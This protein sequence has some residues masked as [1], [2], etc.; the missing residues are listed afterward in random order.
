[1]KKL[2]LFLLAFTM[3]GAT[4]NAATT[5]TTGV[6]VGIDGGSLSITSPIVTTNFGNIVMDA[7]TKVVTANLGNLSVSDLTATGQGWRVLVQSSQF[8]EVG[9]AGFVLPQNSLTL[10]KPSSVVA[11]GGT[12]SPNPTIVPA[13]N[14]VIDDGNQHTVLSAALNN[15]MGSYDMSFANPSL[16]LLLDA[17]TAKVDSVNYAGVPTPYS[18]TITWNVVTGP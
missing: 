17:A 12:T 13:G 7:Q 5:G 9:G 14:T 1:M 11:T 16:S 8:S 15:G 3:F 18:A 6:N 2:G 10:A 4:A